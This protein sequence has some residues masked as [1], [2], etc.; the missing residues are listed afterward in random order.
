MKCVII[1]LI[2]LMVQEMVT[3]Q[4][5][6]LRLKNRVDS[7]LKSESNLNVD[8]SLSRE[9]RKCFECMKLME[10]R[11]KISDK[12]FS[13]RGKNRKDFVEAMTPR[14]YGCVVK[15]TNN[16]DCVAV[17]NF[18]S[19]YGNTALCLGKKA[20]DSEERISESKDSK[21]FCGCVAKGGGTS[22]TSDF[23]CPGLDQPF[24]RSVDSGSDLKPESA[25]K[26]GKSSNSKGGKSSNSKVEQS[27]NPKVNADSSNGSSSREERKCKQC[28]KLMEGRRK[29]SDKIFHKATATSSKARREFNMVRNKFLNEMTPRDYC[30]QNKDTFEDCVSVVNFISDQ[31]KTAQCVGKLD[32]ADSNKFCGCVA[33]QG[34]TRNTW[35]ASDLVCPGK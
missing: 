25:S 15:G 5:L 27:S 1:V 35:Q 6:S 14:E 34:G 33:E 8:K 21:Q 24:E 19:D 17:V 4:S 32:S 2:A 30:E 20:S 9:Q 10:G 29:L 31:Y 12:I 16:Y 28:M 13:K 11:R 23:V 22:Q 7:V 3:V 26:G 18:I